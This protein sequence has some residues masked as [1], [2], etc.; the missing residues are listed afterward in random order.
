ML[1]IAG[2]AACALSI[3]SIVHTRHHIVVSNFDLDKQIFG[4]GSTSV[5]QQYSKQAFQHLNMVLKVMML[6]KNLVWLANERMSL[7]TSIPISLT[8]NKEEPPVP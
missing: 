6:V 7:Q 3:R 1:L 8:F 4:E 2:V 5:S